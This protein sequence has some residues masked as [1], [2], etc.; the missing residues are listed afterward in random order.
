MRES[1]RAFLAIVL[2]LSDLNPELQV[3]FP[4]NEMG[5][6]VHAGRHDSR[7]FGTDYAMPGTVEEPRGDLSRLV[8]FLRRNLIVVALGALVGGAVS[9]AVLR[10]MPNRYAAQATIVLDYVDTRIDPA[11]GEI[12]SNPLSPMQVE[13]EMDV[14]ASRGFARA[15]A[16]RLN[17]VTDPYL[18]PYLAADAPTDV[19]P[20]AQL[21]SVVTKLMASYQV[22]R[23][24]DS[25]A[26]DII[27][28]HRDRTQAAHVANAVAEIYIA[29]KLADR[30]EDVSRSLVYLQDRV[31]ALGLA[32]AASESTVAAFIRDN[33]LDRIRYSEELRTEIDRVKSLMVLAESGQSDVGNSASLEAE[34][35]ALET[36]L[37]ERTRNELT[38]VNMQRQLD[39]ETLRYQAFVE[40]RNSLET[41]VDII[42]P[43]VRQI[44]TAEPPVAPYSPD[45]P[46][47]MTAGIALGLIFGLLVAFLRDVSASRIVLASEAEAAS[48]LPNLAGVPVLRRRRSDGPRA[49]LRQLSA[50]SRTPYHEAMRVLLTGITNRVVTDGCPIIAISSA[51]SGEGKSTLA[52]SLGVVAGQENQRV[53]LIDFDLQRQG[54]SSLVASEE[55]DQ[56]PELVLR[57]P[58]DLGRH[59]AR[60][61][62]APGVDLLTFRR[63]APVPRNI[64]TLPQ[65]CESFEVMRQNYDL[66]I[67][68]TPPLLA[69]D[70]ASRLAALADAA[71]LVARSRRTT[72]HALRAAVTILF[73]S[74]ANVA[75]IA[76]NAV[77]PSR[78]RSLAGQGY[79]AYAGQG[80]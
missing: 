13:T 79:Y 9:Y 58:A 46:M 55:G 5:D 2:P 49:L 74:K 33:E 66:V 25:L 44:T 12:V 54:L 75:G 11:S 3:K 28:T 42:A 32:L 43:G 37:R 45:R 80:N 59:I 76:L 57:H 62:V 8:Q 36:E 10:Q 70:E 40:R 51:Q 26:L 19:G 77:N 72:S 67:L 50:E 16:D 35:T 63:G 15:V 18:N 56:T 69:A 21:E 52:L 65:Y 7:T 60:N 22:V 71:V 41:Q 61:F 31:Q 30:R 24:G 17:L 38:L 68:D 29:R 34:A 53:L 23:R 64:R 1:F 78:D 6:H 48:G 73:A 4:M 27:A 20:E 14:A 47:G 39:A